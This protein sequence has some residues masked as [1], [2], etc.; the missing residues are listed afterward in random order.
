MRTAGLVLAF[1]VTAE[2]GPIYSKGFVRQPRNAYVP[3]AV[4]TDGMR[5]SAPDKLDYTGTKTSAVKD[6]GRCGSCWAFSATQGVESGIA[7]AT[8]SL[9]DNLATQQLVG[10]DP[11]DGGCNGGDLPTA[12][13]YIKSDGG[14]DSDSHYPDT[15]SRWGR[16]GSCQSHGHVAKVVSAS[17]AIPPC[18]G[19]RC[20]GQDESGLMA[21]LAEHGPLSVCV[22]AETFNDYTSGI[23]INGQSCSG[24]YN[25]LDHCVQLVGYDNS[26]SSPYWK[27]KNS[28]TTGWGEAGFIRLPMGSNYCGIADEAMF[29]T[30]QYASSDVTV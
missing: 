11:T 15:S 26:G 17:Y 28:W 12:F 10:C 30:A 22:N 3:V 27:V 18:A 1:A 4:I 23:G 16:S 6:Q 24:S 5:S 21:A 13:D 14:L 2:A 8:G 29:V 25:H 9:P 19:G 7:M 20:R